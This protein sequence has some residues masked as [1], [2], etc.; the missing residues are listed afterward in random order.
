MMEAASV[1]S[2]LR[3][4]GGTSRQVALE[5]LEATGG[6]SAGEAFLLA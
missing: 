5:T 4:A 6:I 3:K 1:S 2:Q